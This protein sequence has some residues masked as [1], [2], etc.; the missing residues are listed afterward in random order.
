MSSY[1]S[2]DCFR[3]YRITSWDDTLELGS[4]F[5]KC[6]TAAMLKDHTSSWYLLAAFLVFIVKPLYG[7]EI[8]V[9]QPVEEVF[10][11]ELVFPQEKGEI[12][13][14]FAPGIHLNEA[15]HSGY[16]PFSIEYGLTDSWQ[17]EA[18]WSGPRYRSDAA[19]GFEAGSKYS[20]LDIAGQQIHLALGAEYGFSVRSE[21]GESEFGTFLIVA[22][23]FAALG[24]LQVFTQIAKEWE[25]GEEEIEEALEGAFLSSYTAGFVLPGK[26]FHIT[27]E[28]AWFNENGLN[29]HYA[30][31]GIVVDLPSDLQFG[32]GIPI[33][34]SSFSDDLRISAFLTWE[35]ELFEN[36]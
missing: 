15:A 16:S 22:K 24:G 20:F 21:E 25:L 19:S 13:F 3:A 5:I 1:A 17:V 6:Y 4:C 28:Y 30:A 14:L 12:Q 35:L 31:P 11:T 32:I 2:K 23:E 18:E 26:V 9:N 10:L 33:G 8:E 29:Q 34:L 36:D 7:Q 27:G